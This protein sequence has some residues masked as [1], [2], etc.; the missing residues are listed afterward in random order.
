[1]IARGAAGLAVAIGLAA[2]TAI[3]TATYD[4]QSSLDVALTVGGDVAV[5]EPP[6][7]HASP[8][9]GDRYASAPGA[10]RIEP[11]QHRFAY[12]GPDLQDLYGI[13]PATI[14]TAAPLRDSFV[15]GGTIEQALSGLAQ[16]P[17]GVLLSAE[18]LHD[19]QLHPG[20]P[21]RLQLQTGPTGIYQPVQF[22]VMG[23]IDEFPTAPKDSFIVANADYLSQATGSD[24][25]STFLIT[26]SDPLR[27]AEA[28]RDRLIGTGAEVHDVISARSSVATATGLAA[29]DLSGLSKLELGFGVL[30]ALACS[31]LALT[32]GIAD[33]RRALVIL[34]VLGAS[35]RQRGRFL[36]AEARA[37]LAAGLTGGAVI[38]VGIDYLLI[39]VL[40]GIFDPPPEEPTLPW[41]YLAS[42]GA[43]TIAATVG[44]VTIY[45]RIAGRAGPA[46]L[47]D[48]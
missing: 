20:D 41:G 21:V 38:A 10:T 3:F 15:A 9:D 4:A 22:H 29:T 19:Y 5:V 47:R 7:A 18:T 13:R 31:G 17:D 27:T 46:E 45:G 33:R 39:K 23:E 48:L 42:L 25:V 37:L 28:L 8:A 32:L 2:S 14:G 36:A 16:T 30:L 11:L 12:V 44:V 40:T 43:A 1:V 26:S 24:A 35:S 6:G 34:A